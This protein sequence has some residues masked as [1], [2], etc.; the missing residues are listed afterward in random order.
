[1]LQISALTLLALLGL[2]NLVQA[3][4]APQA[5]TPAEPPGTP[6]GLRGS[7]SHLGVTGHAIDQ[8]ESA[9]VQNYDELPAQKANAN[10][11]FYFDF[12][13]LQN[14]QPIRG[15]GGTDPGPSTSTCSTKIFVTD[16]VT[17]KL[18]I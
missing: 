12:T 14:P 1:M 13:K 9:I 8:W 4:P 15:R 11:G 6:A 3:L 7:E 2:G 10:L 5:S 18:Q 17:R 16:S